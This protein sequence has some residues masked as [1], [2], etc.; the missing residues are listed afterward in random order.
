VEIRVVCQRGKQTATFEVGRGDQQR[1]VTARA[2]LPPDAQAGAPA[3]S[4]SQSIALAQD[5]LATSLAE[6]L[7]HLEPDPVWER[8]LSAATGLPTG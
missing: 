7:T 8:A 4:A 2:L 6:A 1:T 5:P 3:P